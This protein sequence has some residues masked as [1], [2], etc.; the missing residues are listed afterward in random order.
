MVTDD[1]KQTIFDWFQYREVS[2]DDKFGVFINRVISRDYNAYRE[3]LRIQ[4]GYARYDWLVTQYFERQINEKNDAIEKGSTR[5]TLVKS[6]TDTIT[7]NGNNLKSGKYVETESGTDKTTNKYA[8]NITKT[9]KE[10]SVDSFEDYKETTDSDESVKYDHL[11]QTK[12]G[13][14]VKQTVQYDDGTPDNPESKDVTDTDSKAVAKAAPQSISYAGATSGEIPELDWDYPSSQNQDN[15]KTT[16]K[17]GKHNITSTTTELLD[18]TYN[19]EKWTYAGSPDDPKAG[20]FTSN[21]NELKKT[22]KAINTVTYGD[23]ATGDGIVDAKSG[24][25]F[26]WTKYGK[27][28]THEYKNWK[29]GTDNTHK[30]T[31]GSSHSGGSAS[32]GRK[33][34]E[35]LNQSQSAGRQGDTGTLLQKASEFIMTSSAWAWLSQRLEVC[36]QGVYDL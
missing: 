13:A 27:S 15:G 35:M 25:D 7:D 8:S 33:Q 17:Y 5:N 20:D 26:E 31:Y 23:E 3:L 9:G 19:E 1:L 32:D 24:K 28:T 6:G 21:H 36:F 10:A 22:G 29:D 16:Q 18:D 4:P 34:S 30:T 2:D 12:P 14:K 11:I